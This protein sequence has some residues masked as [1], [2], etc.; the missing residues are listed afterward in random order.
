MEICYLEVS[1]PLRKCFR[2]DHLMLEDLS[3]GLAIVQGEIYLIPFFC[4]NEKDLS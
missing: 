4:K 2:F 1:T 3:V